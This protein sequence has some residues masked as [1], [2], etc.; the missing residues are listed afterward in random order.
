VTLLT[1]FLNLLPRRRHALEAD[2]QEELQALRDLVDPTEARELGNL[3]R[4]TENAREQWGIAWLDQF[5]RDVR[6][7]YRTLRKSPG[8]TI[9]CVAVLALGIG[10]NTAIF[11]VVEAVILRPL[12]Y[13]QVNRLVHVWLKIPSLP[14]PLGPRMQVSRV[15]FQEWQKQTDIFSD[16]AAYQE[17]PLTETGFERPSTVSTGYATGNLF[18][19]LGAYA[20]AGRSFSPEEQQK[21][22]D[23]V[24]ILSDAYFEKR[25]HREASAL[26]KS[27]TLGKIDYTIIGAL[28]ST[29]KLPAIYGGMEQ[30]KPDL[31]IPVSRLW[32][33]ANDDTSLQLYV[34]GL[35]QPGVKID[36]ARTVISALQKRL[37][38]SD[39]ERFVIEE[40]NINP[41][42]VEAKSEEVNLALYV[43]LGAVGFLLLIGCANLANLTMARATKRAREISIR[44]ALGASRGRIILQ[45]LTESL[46]VATL[47]AVAGLLLS[48]GILVALTRIPT[49]VP[50]PDQLE[51]NLPVLAFTAAISLL[52]TLL[53][54]L[55]PAV[56]ASRVSVNRALKSRGGGGA[57]ATLGRS[58]QFLTAIE[59]GLAVILLCG[60]GLLLRSFVGLLRTGLGFDTHQLLVADVDLP[61]IRYPDSGGRERYYQA[62][63]AKVKAIPGVTFAGF[64]NTLPIHSTNFSTFTLAGKP[65]PKI[66]ESPTADTGFV[67]L[68][69]FQSVGLPIRAGRDFTETDVAQN[70]HGKGD[71]V[72]MINQAFAD[73]FFRN[74]N[75]LGQRV[76]FND[77]PFQVVGVATNFLVWGGID[78]AH[79]QFFV[80]GM[81]G[82]KGLLI[83]RTAVPPA[84]IS[85]EVRNAMLSLDKEL[86]VTKVETMDH[87][88]DEVA[89]EPKSVLVLLSTFAGLALLLA[90]IGVY[91]VLAN[92]V[93]SR[94]R[95]IGIRMAL[96]ATPQGIGRMV[97]A[98]SL[99]PVL[100]GLVVGLAASLA[101]SRLL[102]DFLF[103]VSPADPLTFALTVSAIAIAAPLAVWGPVRRATRVECTVALREE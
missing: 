98:Q 13:P 51:L 58:R 46:I 39:P 67:S 70:L 3:T 43:L 60:S 37:N 7:A 63:L 87:S 6:M 99:W 19:L 9:A 55:A 21:G 54:G 25:F 1:R 5:L 44:R 4:A 76:L 50:Q 93:A 36:Q 84:T 97:A 26:G 40:S 83:L 49:I 38:K 73:K 96:G 82:P 2:A 11:S 35:L 42:D 62:L 47:G 95:E 17:A 65:K 10:A 68:G 31:W 23:H 8:Y 16:L 103:G 57:S 101:V 89:T 64:S 56:S 59:V 66:S 45:L 34:I 12:Q 78:E 86:P 41:L 85:D 102:T 75:P 71:G 29:F 52:T 18:H 69:Y 88:I 33:V 72:M 30:K 14:E 77:R 22:A 90:M 15:I 61:D 32:N 80:A 28:P 53:F 27:V 92:L 48:K 81:D 100:G 24:V 94:T 79:P 20:A 74:E 91:S